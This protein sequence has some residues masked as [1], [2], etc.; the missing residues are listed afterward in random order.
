MATIRPPPASASLG[1][2][3]AS[4]DHQPTGAAV[5]TSPHRPNSTNAMAT[6][7]PTAIKASAIAAISNGI[8]TRVRYK[9]LVKNEPISI[10]PTSPPTPMVNKLIRSEG[11][12]SEL[13]SIIRISTP[14]I[15]SHNKTTN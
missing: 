7:P 1:R 9:P 5:A 10:V 4:H 2:D 12:T 15:F 8:T 6:E 13:H 11:H 3:L 14:V